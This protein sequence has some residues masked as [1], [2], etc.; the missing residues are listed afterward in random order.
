MRG[1]PINALNLAV[2]AL[3][4][5]LREDPTAAKRIEVATI[6][7][8]TQVRLIHDFTPATD[9][10]IPALTVWGQTSMAEALHQAFDMTETC[11]TR[12][13][14]G[15]R[16]CLTPV[17]LLLTDGRPHS[18]GGHGR[19]P[20]NMHA[21]ATK[22]AAAEERKE[23]AF[24]AVGV[25]GR[26]LDM[27]LL[28]RLSVREPAR[29]DGLNFSGLLTWLKGTLQTISQAQSDVR[30]RLPA[31]DWTDGRTA[32]PSGGWVDTDVRVFAP[33]RR[34]YTEQLLPLPQQLVTLPDPLPRI[35]KSWLRRW[36]ESYFE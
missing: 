1:A 12:H 28:K 13:L 14:R 21:I 2:R 4:A 9:L 35:R 17:M 20:P 23:L 15:G 18:Y 26:R 10:N 25:P 5:G 19:M 6:A 22:I 29:L 32:Q 8:G 31:V 30:V 33:E 24:F 27:A 3:E 34:V 36:I 11:M 16:H 7:F